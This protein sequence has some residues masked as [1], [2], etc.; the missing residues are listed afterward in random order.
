META[1]DSSARIMRIG[2]IIM[3]YGLA[4]TFLWVGLLK[5]TA[6]EA[7]G[8]KGL[9]EN[10]PFL[11][12]GID[13]FG[14]QGYSSGIGVIE[15]IMAL[16]IASREFSPKLSCIGSI[17]ASIFFVITLTFVFTTPTM[18]QEG[19]G[20]PFP[21]PN[22]GQFLLKDL[23]FFGVSLWLAGEAM[24]AARRYEKHVAN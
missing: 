4:I 5:F 9:L 6:Y 1:T 24:F 11:S 21:S 17:G 22:P 12:W 14:L 8:I 19:Y 2:V 23:V 7:E 10:S 13:A 16:L 15:I 20:F 18:W 3:R